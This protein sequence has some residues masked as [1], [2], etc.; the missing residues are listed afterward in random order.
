MIDDEYLNGQARLCGWQ[1]TIV[2][3]S[4]CRHANKEQ[5]CFPSIKLMAEENGVS[6]DTILKGI[7]ALEKRKVISVKKTRSKGGKWLNNS[8][9]LLD[10]SEWI[11]N[12]VDENDMVHQVDISVTPSRRERLG[13]VGHNDTKET[14]KQGNT[15][16]IIHKKINNTSS[17]TT[18]NNKPM[19]EETTIELDEFGEVIP[20]KPKRTGTFGKHTRNVANYYA[21][22]HNK[23]VTGQTMAGAKQLLSYLQKQYPEENNQGLE[24]EA[25][26]CIN[27]AEKYY[28]GKNITDWGIV[29]VIENINKFL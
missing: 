3:L 29:K 24:V 8:Y 11:Y 5:T 9:V 20:S 21:A 10:K 22:K 15:Y 28:K 2:Y 27:L 4:L 1:G 12:Q 14:H 23:N 17:K 6:R 26:A 7:K 18:S 25:K 19:F 16:N 13:R